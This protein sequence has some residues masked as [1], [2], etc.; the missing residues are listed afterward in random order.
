MTHSVKF[1]Q[2]GPSYL[3]IFICDYYTSVNDKSNMQ[4]NFLNFYINDR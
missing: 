3:N 1:I 2:Q 4:P